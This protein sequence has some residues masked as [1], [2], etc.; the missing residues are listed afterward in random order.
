[1]H[2]CPHVTPLPL[3][4]TRKSVVSRSQKEVHE[5]PREH[6]VRGE[7]GEVKAKLFDLFQQKSHFSIEELSLHTKQP[8]VSIYIYIC[9]CVCASFSLFY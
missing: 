7:M 9:V 2:A 4:R 3:T 6:F 5:R 8:K 1:M